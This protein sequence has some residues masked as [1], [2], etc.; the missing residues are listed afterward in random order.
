M[1][2]FNNRKSWAEE[3]NIPGDKIPRYS[4]F[5]AKCPGCGEP[6]GMDDRDLPARCTICGCKY[7]LSGKILEAKP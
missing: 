1:P 4:I 5:P 7:D 2:K 3:L 6:G